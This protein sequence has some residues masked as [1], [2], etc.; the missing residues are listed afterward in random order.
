MWDPQPQ[1]YAW[2]ASNILGKQIQG[3]VYNLVTSINPFD[4]PLLKNGLPSKGVKSTVKSTYE[5]Y[6]MT[7]LQR[8]E[9][10][11][12]SVETVLA[13][14]AE[15]LAYMRTSSPRLYV[16][17]LHRVSAAMQEQTAK[18]VTRFSE[19]MDRALNKA[20]D[21]NYP[22]PYKSRFTCPNCRV[23]MVCLAMDEGADWREL[24]ERDFEKVSRREE[25]EDSDA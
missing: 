13:N 24:L 1:L 21:G 16:R 10:T 15:E 14:Y 20:A 8:A 17:H 6:L 2:A 9:A 18:H 4:I 11:G 22:L 19:L 23:R 12:N 3:V 25:D 7:L 5:V